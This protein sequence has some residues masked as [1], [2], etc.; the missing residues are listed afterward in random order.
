M[1]ADMVLVSYLKNSFDTLKYKSHK[2]CLRPSGVNFENNTS[3]F[4][5][6]LELTMST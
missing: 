2:K 3:F 1:F 4:N 6:N 5:A